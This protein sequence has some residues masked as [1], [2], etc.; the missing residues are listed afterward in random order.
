MKTEMFNGEPLAAVNVRRRS[1]YIYQWKRS[2]SSVPK[3]TRYA[4]ERGCSRW[5]CRESNVN[6]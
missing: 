1:Q 3:C 6:L 4:P 5:H 2:Q